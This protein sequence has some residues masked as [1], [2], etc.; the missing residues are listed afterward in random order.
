MLALSFLILIGTALI[1]EGFHFEIPKGYIY[2][3]MVFSLGVEILNL[4]IR[5]KGGAVP[6]PH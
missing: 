3:A 6:S 4:R 1:A 2:F 5:S